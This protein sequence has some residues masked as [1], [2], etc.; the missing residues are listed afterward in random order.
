MS[1]G[2]LLHKIKKRDNLK[3]AVQAIGD[4][5]L[6]ATCRLSLVPSPLYINGT[7]LIVAVPKKFKI[8][9]HKYPLFGIM[10]QSKLKGSTV[11]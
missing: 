8:L 6:S 5:V 1:T 2:A 7:A 11:V 9:L 4:R 10:N 3:S